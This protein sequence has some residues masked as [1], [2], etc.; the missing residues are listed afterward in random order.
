[1][2]KN[3]LNK[4]IR[5]WFG[6]AFKFDSKT[7]SFIPNSKFW[8]K[9]YECSNCKRHFKTMRDFKKHKCEEK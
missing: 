9:S 4:Q 8:T 7:G 6:E 5:G 2:S 3:E 1:M